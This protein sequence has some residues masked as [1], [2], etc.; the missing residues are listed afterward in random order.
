MS[1]FTQFKDPYSDQDGN[2]PPPAKDFTQFSDPYEKNDEQPAP[3]QSKAET[4]QM[5]AVEAGLTAFNRPF[6]RVA[7]GA[8]QLGKSGLQ[9]VGLMDEGP[10]ALEAVHAQGEAQLNKAYEAHPNI[11]TGAQI[12]GTIGSLA[13]A[14]VIPGGAGGLVSRTAVGAATG[15]GF[16]ATQWSDKEHSRGANIIAGALFGGAASAILPKAIELGGTL[17]RGIKNSRSPEKIVQKGLAA[18]DDIATTKAA[19]SS[20]DNLGVNLT[21]GEASRSA[22]LLGREARLNVSP[23]QQQKLAQILKARNTTVNQK[24][25]EVI[26]SLVSEGDDVAKANSDALYAEIRPQVLP[27]NVTQSILSN[28]IIAKN[29]DSAMA[30][31]NFLVDQQK[32]GTVGFFDELKKYMQ[33]EGEKEALSGGSKKAYSEAIHHLTGAID[34]AVPQY[35]VA[36]GISQRII[37]KRNYTDAIANIKLAKGQDA[38]EPAQIYKELF[39]TQ[40]QQSKFFDEVQNAKGNVGQARDV[41]EVMKRLQTSTIGKVLGKSAVGERTRFQTGQQ[42][43]HSFLVSKI[44][45]AW[46]AGPDRILFELVTNKDWAKQLQVLKNVKPDSDIWT[47]RVGQLFDG[48]SKTLQKPAVLGALGAKMPPPAQGA[49]PTE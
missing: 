24:A 36:R 8:M 27:E 25:D 39:G 16:G 7:E 17:F 28:P 33:S 6:E 26:Q 23:D 9:A 1:D 15:A 22:A 45:D 11:A 46:N 14:A 12:A 42:D 31:K 10:G 35:G 38:P 3:E 47:R 20:A 2:A 40:A 30:S 32:P 44:R 13:N 43:T 37:Q 49:A 4:P 34:E 19:Q 5:G 18:G 29:L 21:P 48:L 41:M